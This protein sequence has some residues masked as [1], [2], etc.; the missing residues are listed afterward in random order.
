MQIWQKMI[1]F[2]DNTKN[3]QIKTNNNQDKDK[4]KDKCK[5]IVNLNNQRIVLG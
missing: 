3:N 4:N 5:T 1:T 2:A